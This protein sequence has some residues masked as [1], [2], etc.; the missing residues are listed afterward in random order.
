V[1]KPILENLS[2]GLSSQHISIRCLVI[3]DIKLV[4]GFIKISS[5]VATFLVLQAALGRTLHPPHAEDEII[6]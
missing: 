6:H 3:R 1:D 4:A 5:V 2:S